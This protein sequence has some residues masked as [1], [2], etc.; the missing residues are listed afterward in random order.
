MIKDLQIPLMDLILCL[1]ETVDLISQDLSDHHIQVAFIASK[2][3]QELNLPVK[4]QH[5]LL[6]AGSLHDIG[7][8]SLKEKLSTLNFETENNLKH[9]QVGYWLLNTFE[10]FSQAA[11]LVKY[12]HCY[13]GQEAGKYEN[14]EEVLDGS[15][16]LHLADRIA[17]HIS[18]KGNILDQVEGIRAKIN[19]QSGHMFNPR[20]VEAFQSLASKEYFWLSLETPRLKYSLLNN[21]PLPTLILDLDQVIELTQLFSHIIDFRSPFTAN[22]SSGVAASA[23]ALAEL[24]GFSEYESKMMEIAG[25]LH[26]LGKLA[27]PTELLDKEDK[28][29]LEEFNIVKK[30]VFYTYR[31]LDRIEAFGT[32]NTWASFHHEHLN[33]NGYPFH[34][35]AKDLSLGARILAVADVLTA[36]I[37]NRPYRKGLDSKEALK[38][39]Q[40]NVKAG[41]LDSYVVDVLEKNFELINDKRKQAQK[42]SSMMYNRFSHHSDMATI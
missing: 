40:E 2:L 42:E 31:A 5:Q 34:H 11:N 13:W 15:H 38:L 12:H 39:I 30:H 28:L 25:Y 6:M 21:V 17:V 36:L 16:I 7:V 8:L 4:Q 24:V 37:E 14:G 26:D 22:H 19:R 10:P 35:I 29:T 32:I 18:R 27:I 33:G 20:H 23:K 41:E 3:A 1:S 9:A